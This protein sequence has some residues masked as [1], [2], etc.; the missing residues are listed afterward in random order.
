MPGIRRSPAFRTVVDNKV[1]IQRRRY[2]EH[3]S[4]LTR[5]A[6]Q[7]VL[8]MNDRQMV[9]DDWKRIAVNREVIIKLDAFFF[10]IEIPRT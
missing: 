8:T 10:R 5:D 2:I 1:S 6:L 4:E 9:L 7:A 3:A